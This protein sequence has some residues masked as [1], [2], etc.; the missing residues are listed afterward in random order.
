MPAGQQAKGR[1]RVKASTPT[2][3]PAVTAM[4]KGTSRK[5]FLNW[6]PS[7]KNQD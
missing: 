1:A 2:K 4:L 5:S 3:H 6:E 7:L